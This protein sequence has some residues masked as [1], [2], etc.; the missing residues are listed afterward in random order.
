MKYRIAWTGPGTDGIV[1]GVVLFTS[2]E[3]AHLAA[4]V[5]RALSPNRYFWVEPAEEVSP[6]SPVQ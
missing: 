6:A 5:L 2:L 1:A 4:A 3:T